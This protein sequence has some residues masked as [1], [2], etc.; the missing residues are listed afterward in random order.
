LAQESAS[1]EPPL[2]PEKEAI[3]RL[4]KLEPEVEEE[5]TVQDYAEVQPEEE[6]AAQL[7]EP[8][9]KKRSIWDFFS[10]K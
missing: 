6:A 2:L 7:P 10:R 1:G 3:K 8:K 5:N 9:K 4:D